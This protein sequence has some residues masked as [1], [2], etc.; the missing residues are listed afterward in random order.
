MRA[1][2]T[3][4]PNTTPIAPKAVRRALSTTYDEESGV[5]YS[6]NSQLGTY[7]IADAPVAIDYIYLSFIYK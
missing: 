1:R 5:I 6:V 2:R 7:A 4:S 3:P